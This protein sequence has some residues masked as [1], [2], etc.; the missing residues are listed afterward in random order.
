MVK[1]LTMATAAGEMHGLVNTLTNSVVFDD[2]KHMSPENKAKV[3]KE[4]KE[5]AKMVKVKY[6]NSR[7]KHERLSKP[8]CR[9]AGDPIYCYHLIPGHVYD[10]PM[11]F[12]KEV[13]E[14]K[15]PK[16][17]GLVSLDGNDLRPNGEPLSQDTEAE[18]LH[19]LVP[20]SF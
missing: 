17:S 7:G 10:V 5:D 12:V 8:Y 15:V 1:Q 2:F 16:R 18:Q 14:V 20:A 19:M 6:I 4:K 9:Y 13:N 3:E 11:G